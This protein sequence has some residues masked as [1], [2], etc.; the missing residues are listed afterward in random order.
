[1]KSAREA[2]EW[3]VRVLMVFTDPFQDGAKHKMF[4]H[5]TRNTFSLNTS[6]CRFLYNHTYCDVVTRYG[7]FSKIVRDMRMIVII[8]CLSLREIMKSRS[9][10]DTEGQDLA[11]PQT[12][13]AGATLASILH[14][15]AMKALKLCSISVSPAANPPSAVV[16][17]DSIRDIVQTERRTTSFLPAVIPRRVAHT[18]EIGARAGGRTKI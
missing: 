3:V 9:I 2:G 11:E 13:E 6:N 12:F 16:T 4:G 8:T 7:P 18:I 1:M 10:L 15:P 5:P 14:I 17:C